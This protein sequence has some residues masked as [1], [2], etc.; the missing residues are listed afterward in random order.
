MDILGSERT[1]LK[2]LIMRPL[3]RKRKK[4]HDHSLNTGQW[5]DS[6]AGLSGVAPELPLDWHGAK[7]EWEET[8]KEKKKK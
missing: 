5:R 1:E 7:N 3:D 2:G 8:K 4:N 6:F